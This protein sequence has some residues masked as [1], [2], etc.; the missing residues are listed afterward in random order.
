MSA[1]GCLD[2]IPLSF[3]NTTSMKLL[4]LFF[5]LLLKWPVIQ[6]QPALKVI[7]TQLCDSTGSPVVLRGM[8]FGWHNYHPRFY[9]AGAVSWLHRDWGCNIVR[10]AIGVDP[11]QGYIKDPEL[12]MEK[13]IAVADAAIREN[14]YCIIDWHSHNIRLEEA[15][16]FFSAMAKRYGHTPNVIYELFNEP[17][18]ESW[19]EV[20]AYSAALVKTI[21]AIDPDNIIL[22]GSPHWDQDIQLPAE[23][24]LRG[25]DN[26][27]Y[28]VHY[29]AGTHGQ[30]LR[31]RADSAIRK[32]LPVFISESAGME[33]TGD[34]PINE[35]EWTKWITWAEERK[36][37]WLTWS[38]SDKDETCS[39]LKKSAASAGGWTQAEL[40]T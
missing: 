35:S 23:D 3:T 28:T 38:V 10:A 32:G 26:L 6:A 1:E 14:I 27:M 34:G 36:I 18:E 24:P 15:T 39:V 20:K 13:L 30:W 33:A 7:G 37:S 17:D 9:N 16:N 29:Y 40:K 11:E 4:P 21:R 5:M 8:S 2:L 19:A 25:A 12:A 22:L 31:D